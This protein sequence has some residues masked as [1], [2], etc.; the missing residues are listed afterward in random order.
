MR[1][2][3]FRFTRFR[4]VKH[5]ED[6][7]SGVE[8]FWCVKK[9]GWWGKMMATWVELMISGDVFLSWLNVKVMKD[10]GWFQDYYLA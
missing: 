2:D 7:I 10:F 1:K 6:T 3:V 5:A 4:C 9:S 8:Q